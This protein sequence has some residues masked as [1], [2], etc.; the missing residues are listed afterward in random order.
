MSIYKK[1][2]QNKYLH[3]DVP[4]SFQQ[5]LHMWRRGEKT[6]NNV[7]DSKYIEVKKK[8][9]KKKTHKK[10]TNKKQKKTVQT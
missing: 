10:N 9:L 2:K 6:T 5:V 1:L 7:S 3:T 8:K 4:A